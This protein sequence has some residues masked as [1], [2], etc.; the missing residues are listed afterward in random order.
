MSAE[1]ST[2]A[3]RPQ[4]QNLVRSSSSMDARAAERRAVIAQMLP[5]G[6]YVQSKKRCEEEC[7]NSIIS[8]FFFPLSDASAHP[9]HIIR[10]ES[11][12]SPTNIGYHNTSYTFTSPCN[13][14]RLANT[15]EPNHHLRSPQSN[16]AGSQVDDTSILIRTPGPIDP[17][18]V[19]CICWFI[20][21]CWMSQHLQQ[22]LISVI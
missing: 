20:S 1:A 9:H 3:W 14:S 21:P 8:T 10:S 22:S 17:S 19:C 16:S 4:K 2:S 12:A 5:E 6:R 18:C 15:G 11:H 7:C 13:L